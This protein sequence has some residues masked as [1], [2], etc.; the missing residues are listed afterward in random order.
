M[1]IHEVIN[2][3]EMVYGKFGDE[4]KIDAICLENCE[5]QLGIKLPYALRVLY[6]YTG[7]HLLHNSCDELIDIN[8]LIISGGY[9]VFYKQDQES[10]LWGID[11]NEIQQSDPQVWAIYDDEV[12]LDSESISDFLSYT[13]AWQAVNGGAL[14]Y[15][16]IIDEYKREKKQPFLSTL[17]DFGIF[18]ADTRHGVVRYKKGIFIIHQKDGEGFIG[19][20]T[21]QE[22][23]FH[24]IV[25]SIGIAIE[26]WTITSFEE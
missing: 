17:N 25:K 24:E 10:I 22:S 7:R 8:K 13:A 2:A 20:A 12:L 9:L 19:V 4:A 26:D 3:V 15:Y 14:P 16:G 6:K 18:L 5:K 1:K 23:L 21:S 11:I